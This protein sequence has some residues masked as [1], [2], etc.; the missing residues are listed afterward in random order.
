V[1]ECAGPGALTPSGPVRGPM[2]GGPQQGGHY[3]QNQPQQQ[4]Q[5]GGQQQRPQ[6]QQQHQQ[7]GQYG[8]PEEG[9]G[10]TGGIKNLFGKVFV[11]CDSCTVCV[12]CLQLSLCNDPVAL[13][14][15]SLPL[16]KLCMYA[17]LD[18]TLMMHHCTLQWCLT[19]VV[20]ITIVVVLIANCVRS[21]CACCCYVAATAAGDA[22]A[23]AVE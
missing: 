14:F 9:G 20:T 2:G 8:Q 10:W 16:H 12:H 19:L 13:R 7:Q 6:Q 23:A 22:A 3:T 21:Y 1:H 15:A 4:Q 11:V 17:T 18:N 5:Y